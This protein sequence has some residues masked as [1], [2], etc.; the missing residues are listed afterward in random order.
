MDLGELKTLIQCYCQGSVRSSR[1]VYDRFFDGKLHMLPTLYRRLFALIYTASATL[2]KQAPAVA[3]RRSRRQAQPSRKRRRSGP[4]PASDR[5][6]FDHLRRLRK[7]AQNCC[8]L[9][10]LL[11][12]IGAARNVALFLAS[13]RPLVGRPLLCEASRELSRDAG[14]EAEFEVPRSQSPVT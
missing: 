2:T 7:L 9:L 6:Q 12:L 1:D 14:I 10:P 3:T 11:K 8:A 13:S 4:S 5:Q